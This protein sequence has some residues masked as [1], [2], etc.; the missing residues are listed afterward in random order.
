MTML[1]ANNEGAEQPAHSTAWSDP[2][3]FT[4]PCLRVHP[5]VAGSM[6][7]SEHPKTGFLVLNYH[8]ILLWDFVGPSFI[9]K[10]YKI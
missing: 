10:D 8:S 6:A 4:V 3:V 1:Y 5:I 7:Q 9:T 2:K